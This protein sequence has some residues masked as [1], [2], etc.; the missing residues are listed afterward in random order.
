MLAARSLI[1]TPEAKHQHSGTEQTMQPTISVS[2]KK[3]K[4]LK[5]MFWGPVY[6]LRAPNTGTFINYLLR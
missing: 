5:R 2:K 4:N 6:I 1:M 3:I